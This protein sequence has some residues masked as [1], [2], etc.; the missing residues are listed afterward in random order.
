MRSCT[1]KTA[2]LLALALACAKPAVLSPAEV[3]GKYSFTLEG[4]V[5]ELTLA[6]D[7]TFLHASGGRATRGRW[8]LDSMQ[9]TTWIHLDGF[10]PW[11]QPGSP[12]GELATFLQR[13]E[14]RVEI[15]VP[16]AQVWYER[17]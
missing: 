6:P 8:R 2:L 1:I 10:D 5:D 3:A 11:W 17:R 4:R 12:R 14:G 13:R 9:G 16:G 7:G 15:R